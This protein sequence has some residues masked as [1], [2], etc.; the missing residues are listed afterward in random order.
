MKSKQTNI[1]FSE[2]DMEKLT[3][4]K[5]IYGTLTRA[6]TIAIERLYQE[7]TKKPPQE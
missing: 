7:E 5:K 1:R 6:V 3:F 2:K 4:L